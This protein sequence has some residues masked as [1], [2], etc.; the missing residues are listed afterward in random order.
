M[1]RALYHG[2]HDLL[3]TAHVT[4]AAGQEV[5]LDATALYPEAGGQAA[6]TG[7]LRWTGADGAPRAATVTHSR[8]EKAAGLIWHAL[9]G[10]VPPVGTPVKGRWTPRAAGGTRSGTAPNTCWPRPSCA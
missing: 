8:Q 2:S 1:T 10:D 5:A 9:T 6:D 7:T 3:F 4:H